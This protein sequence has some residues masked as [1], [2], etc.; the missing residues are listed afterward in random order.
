MIGFGG[1][2]GNVVVLTEI[3]TCQNKKRQLQSKPAAGLGRGLRS[4]KI[5]GQLRLEGTLEVLSNLLGVCRTY[6]H[7]A[8]HFLSWG[9]LN[10]ICCSRCGWCMLRRGSRH[11]PPSTDPL[12]PLSPSSL[13]GCTAPRGSLTAQWQPGA[14]AAEL[15]SGQ[16]VS[17][18]YGG[19]GQSIQCS[20]L[21]T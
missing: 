2:Q 18:L 10:C 14:F 15:L 1:V 16:S 17:N 4:H 21:Q 13:L 11:C 9:W 8:P 7:L 6:S 20:G 19:R 3:E 12:G 5:P